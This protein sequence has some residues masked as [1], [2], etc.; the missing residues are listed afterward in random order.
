MKALR[1]RII[2][3]RLT[4]DEMRMLP[5][6]I[7]INGKSKRGLSRS[8]RERLFGSCQQGNRPAHCKHCRLLMAAVNNL[9]LIARRIVEADT[10]DKAAQV[11]A[12]LVAL[13]RVIRQGTGVYKS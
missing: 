4:E 8:V 9:N 5:V 12:H 1:T 13:E 6:P 2:K 7:N 10:S 3:L 11:I